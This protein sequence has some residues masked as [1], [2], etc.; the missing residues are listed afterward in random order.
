MNH[1]VLI[2]TFTEND[3]KNG[4]FWEYPRLQR[5]PG[6][7]RAA[8]VSALL[9]TP[10]VIEVYEWRDGLNGNRGLIQ[11]TEDVKSRPKYASVSHVW[12]S[13]NA[14]DAICREVNRPLRIAKGPKTAEGFKEKP[15]IAS[16]QGL[17]EVAHACRHRGCTHFWLD[18]LC[19]D[20][21]KNLTAPED[22]E[23]KNQIKNMGY[24]YERSDIVFVMVGGVGAAQRIDDDSAWID[25]AW[26]LQEAVVC[27]NTVVLVKW[28]YAG[29]FNAPPLFRDP[30]EHPDKKFPIQFT[31][32]GYN[33]LAYIEI[34]ALL[35]LELTPGQS[36]IDLEGRNE[37]KALPPDFSIKCFNSNV[38]D[39]ISDTLNLSAGR[40]ALMAVIEACALGKKVNK[41]MKHGAIWR[42]MQ[43]RISTNQEDIVFSVL[44]LLEVKLDDTADLPLEELYPKLVEKVA[45]NGIPAWL[46]LG[47]S[48]GDIIPR[49]DDFGLSPALP[50]RKRVSVE[51]TETYLPNYVVDE[52]SFPTSKFISRSGDYISEFDID[53]KEWGPTNEYICCRMFET[54][55]TRL[56]DVRPLAGDAGRYETATLDFP[57]MRALL[58]FKYHHPEK[59]PMGEVIHIVV[60]G[61]IQWLERFSSP[62]SHPEHSS[63]YV[64]I[65][66][67]GKVRWS[68]VGAGMMAILDGE[69]PRNRTHMIFGKNSSGQTV[70]E[71]SC[72]CKN[73][74]SI[75]QPI[76]NKRKP[77]GD[78]WEVEKKKLELQHKEE[79]EKIQIK[80]THLVSENQGIA[81]HRDNLLNKVTEFEQ[82]SQSVHDKN[83]APNK[84]EESWDAE[85]KRLEA[86]HK[87]E[88]ERMGGKLT[89]LVSDHQ[90]I[91][92][93]R[94][95]LL[96][97]VTE[98][99]R[100]A[101][102]VP[103]VKSPTTTQTGGTREAE[104]KLELQ[105]QDEK[106]SIRIRNEE[107]ERAKQS[108]SDEH[109]R[110]SFEKE[111]EKLKRELSQL[112]STK[113]QERQ[114][115]QNLIAEL[116][117]K[118]RSASHQMPFIIAEKTKLER[119]LSQL[120]SAEQRERA[121][122][123]ARLAELERATQPQSG[124]IIRAEKGNFQNETTPSACE[125]REESQGNQNP[126]GQSN[127]TARS[128][129]SRISFT[130]EEKAKLEK[131]LSRLASE[132]Q[133]ERGSRTVES[134][135]KT[136][137]P[138]D[139]YQS[140][141]RVQFQIPQEVT[142][143]ARLEA[144]LRKAKRNSYDYKRR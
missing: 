143:R 21:V 1:P 118:S 23:K 121:S 42:S 67:K 94:D 85:K 76:T 47:G 13:S 59:R 107:L 144:E 8:S 92:Q 14:V 71:R 2:N 40:S 110:K 116:E 32:I 95:G 100:Y 27:P 26:T 24:I 81:Q 4:G 99:E 74:K 22:K 39:T 49:S 141:S 90:K 126:T 123:L 10:A 134:E 114:N 87:G 52:H 113:Q 131:D 125:K 35:E 112:A 31:K 117:R 96:N 25:R 45:M 58:T 88:I 60:I 82:Q 30:D 111:K 115:K 36:I 64:Y 61:K 127:R 128:G 124:E 48:S 55:L 132:E 136:Q 104:N 6:A 11:P 56:T 142:E 38:H 89:R 78:S 103:Q 91:A 65:V 86:L 105:H 12:K 77:T 3:S 5:V 34:K 29:K 138:S 137:P 57:G 44:H 37:S 106:E 108:Q 80:L 28:P 46:G 73:P 98:L 83:L 33:E 130:E 72:V 97:R 140:R 51:N 16:W 41:E 54:K 43:L 70:L 19:I 101:H 135:R 119:D 102:S 68:R 93:E 109:G 133:R 139:G 53:F 63:W 120:A 17:V 7:F 66:E 18:L 69:M 20:Q 15:Q 9:Q 84:T 79:M 129:W 122:L 50:F 75:G 62:V